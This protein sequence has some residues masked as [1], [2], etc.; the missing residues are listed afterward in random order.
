VKRGLPARAASIAMATVYQE[1][2][3]RNLDH[4]D[5]DSV[6][7]FQQ[8]PSQ[9][10]GTVEQIMDPYYSTGKF[11]DALV[12]V[13]DWQSR[14][15]TEVAQAVQRSGHP[16]AYRQHET[17][18]R[19]LAS[20]LAGWTPASL[21]CMRPDRRGDA[22]GLDAF[23]SWTLGV[24]RGTVRETTLVVPVGNAQ[25]AWAVAHLAIATGSRFGTVEV[26]VGSQQWQ[27]SATDLAAWRST[28][29]PAPVR[30]VRIGV[31]AP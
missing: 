24:K 21:S 15:M 12:K 4:G 10:W 23:L 19:T 26:T 5:R 30:E 31:A 13:R 2:G 25:Q 9:G 16:D 27:H 22:A 14:D 3:T 11:Y 1:T 29:T 28:A 17:N 7:L 18:G 6:G 20:S 8:R